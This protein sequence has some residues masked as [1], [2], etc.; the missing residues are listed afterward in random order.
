[1]LTEMA[2][3]IYI[4]ISGHK[5]LWKY[6]LLQRPLPAGKDPESN[7][8]PDFAYSNLCMDALRKRNYNARR[9]DDSRVKNHRRAPGSARDREELLVEDESKL[10]ATF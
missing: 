4:G 9:C 6:V 5:A 7:T 1:M 10:K 2:F 8:M 3:K